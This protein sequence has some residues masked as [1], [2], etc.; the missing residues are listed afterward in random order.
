MDSLRCKESVVPAEQWGSFHTRQC[1]RKIWRDGYCKQHHPDAVEERRKKSE[2]KFRLKM[3][4]NPFKRIYK[5]ELRIVELVEENRKLGEENRI[6]KEAQ[7]NS[8][9]KR[10]EISPEV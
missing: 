5:L 7:P 2:E 6:L 8:L 4:N 9:C 10:I 3:E 1:H